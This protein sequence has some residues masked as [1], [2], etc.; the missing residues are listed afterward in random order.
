MERSKTAPSYLELKTAVAG[1]VCNGLLQLPRV[2]VL[3]VSGGVH[4]S[5]E[6]GPRFADERRIVL[7]EVVSMTVPA[8]HGAGLNLIGMIAEDLLD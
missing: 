5:V 3:V 2:W 7:L 8:V 1:A 4:L 6:Q